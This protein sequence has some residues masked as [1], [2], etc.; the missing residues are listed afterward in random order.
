MSKFLKDLRH[1]ARSLKTHPGYALVAILTVA[2]GVGANTAVFSVVDQVL[3]RP[4]PLPDARALVRIQE[5]HAEAVNLTGATFRD[6]RERTRTLASVMAYRVVTR[7]FAGVGSDAFPEQA[8]VA[9]ISPDF[10]A[11]SGK[12]PALGREFA[13]PDYASKAAETVLLG[14]GLWRRIFGADPNIVGR[15]ILLHGTPARVVG[16]MPP[17][18]DFPQN[19][20][21]W[22]PMTQADARAQNRRSH[23]F[24]VVGR[25]RAGTTLEQA[26]AELNTIAASI[27]TDSHGVDPGITLTAT[28]LQESLVGDVRPALLTLLVAVGFVLLIGCANVAN[29]LLSRIA[30]QQKEI[31][32]RIALGAKSTD[33]LRG[34]LSEALLLAIA[35]GC[36]GAAAG[37]YTVRLIALAYPGAIPRLQGVA[38]DWR[39]M[40]FAIALSGLSAAIAGV[41]PALYIMRSSP[42]R[43][44]A[45]AGRSTDMLSRSRL[46][47]ALLSAELAIALML[48]VGAGLLIRSF[49]RVVRV[50]PG[51]DEKGV[52][53]MSVTLPDASYPTFDSQLQFIQAVLTDLAVVPGV[54]S[55]AAAGVLPLRP[56]P[57]TDFTLDG[58]SFSPENEPSAFVFKATPEYFRT[59]SVPLLAGRSFTPQDTAASPT[60]VVINEA[61]ARRYYPGENPIGRMITMKDWGE[62]LAA[63]IVG[64]VGDTRQDSLEIAAPPAV[65]FSYAQFRQ[66][67]LVT[68]IVAKTDGD[69]HRLFGILRQRIHSQDKHMPV[70][71]TSMEDMVASSLQRRRFM[72]TLLAGFAAIALLL[73]SIG[74]FGVIS[75]SVSQ[76]T[77]EF[78]IRLAVGAQRRQIVAMIIGEGVLSAAL[79]VALG[80]VA[81]LLLVQM[82]R[83]F[84]FGV[85]TT[86]P[87]TFAGVIALLVCVSISASA[88]PAY[89]ATRVDPVEALRHE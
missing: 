44:L 21:A 64:V 2:L 89:R 73:A 3:L 15:T 40:V 78:G 74:L 46:R 61:M 62:P 33:I 10:F 32:T 28:N 68:Y 80:V 13:E 18:F 37:L 63:Q 71:I 47:S 25:L 70:E 83:R 57:E 77:R 5:R 26:R 54:R 12:R 34:V 75:Y 30:S 84:L 45:A 31:A 86:D 23:L 67:T 1:S 59:L 66:G 8:E 53:V 38:V 27:E 58:K 22:I 35:G 24:E 39:V 56:A 60:V 52:A 4:L 17:G 81:S 6:L 51:Y 49:A 11:V 20:Q 48:L 14:D 41:L 43:A 50:D 79:G 65:Y 9:M 72:L 16:V 55:V 29:L 7:N 87:L 69:P 85:S 82:L 42:S 36:I 76:R 88:V 19:V